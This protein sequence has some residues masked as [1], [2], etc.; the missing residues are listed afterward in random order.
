MREVPKLT[1]GQKKMEKTKIKNKEKSRL[2][3]GLEFICRKQV[4]AKG[5]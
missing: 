4:G 1:F 2:D 3:D 5:R